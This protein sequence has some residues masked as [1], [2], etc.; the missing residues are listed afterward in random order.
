[1]VARDV[2]M[3]IHS[4]GDDWQDCAQNA[5]IGLM[6]AVDRFDPHRAVNFQTFARHRV[7]GAVFNGL[8]QLRESLAGSRSTTGYIP[9]RDRFDSLDSDEPGDACDA[10]V[11]TAI[12]LGLGFLLEAQSF[13]AAAATL[14]AHAE[15]EMEQLGRSVLESMAQ[16]GEREQTILTMHYYHHVSFVEIASHLGVT[17]GRVSQ[18][19][20]RA[21]EQL[22][23][24]IGSRVMEE[25]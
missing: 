11:D 10:F 23:A 5:L 15:L 21:L 8:R 14:D 7:R 6:E 20:K 18:L 16:I 9:I 19:H 12:G 3:R 13:P 25:L 4:I 1:M 2:Y 22:R 24:A 17:K